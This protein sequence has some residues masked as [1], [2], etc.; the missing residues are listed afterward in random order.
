MHDIFILPSN[1]FGAVQYPVKNPHPIRS[2]GLAMLIANHGWDLSTLA[3][4]SIK[5]QVL[6]HA[7]LQCPAKRVERERDRDHQCREAHQPVRPR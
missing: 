3:G 6:I 5:K 2:S 7:L 4:G 1:R